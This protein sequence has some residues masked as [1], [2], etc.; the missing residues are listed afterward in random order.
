MLRKFPSSKHA[1][2]YRTAVLGLQFWV[3]RSH[4]GD[5][6]KL[7]VRCLARIAKVYHGETLT[8][9]AG[10]L[11]EPHRVMMSA[12]AGAAEEQEYPFSSQGA[13]ICIVYIVS[14]VR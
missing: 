3:S 8:H 10:E 1:N 5:D 7:S 4:F 6:G 13:V 11:A 12:T 2:G 14:V 9:V